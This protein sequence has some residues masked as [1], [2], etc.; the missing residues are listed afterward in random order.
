MVVTSGN[1]ISVAMTSTLGIVKPAKVFRSIGSPPP[2]TG[3]HPGPAQSCVGPGRDDYPLVGQPV[4]APAS[5][6]VRSTSTAGQEA[7]FGGFF[8]VGGLGTGQRL[9][10]IGATGGDLQQRA[11]QHALGN[12]N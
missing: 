9:G 8:D 3:P 2:V 7:G 4:A 11:P 5:P 1:T 6:G 10:R 12:A